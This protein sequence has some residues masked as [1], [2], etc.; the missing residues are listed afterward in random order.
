MPI[1]GGVPECC[2]VLGGVTSEDRATVL[3]ER[4]VAPGDRVGLYLDKSIEAVAAIYGALKARAAYVPLD[5]RGLASRLGYRRPTRK[6]RL[7]AVIVAP[8]SKVSTTR[9]LWRRPRAIEK[10]TRE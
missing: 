3:I 6:T 4:G 2:E 10:R 5:P 9:A 7:L 1:E 8:S